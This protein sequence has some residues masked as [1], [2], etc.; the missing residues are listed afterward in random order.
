MHIAKCKKPVDIISSIGHSGKGK[1]HRKSK[2]NSDCQ[3]LGSKKENVW[4]DGAHDISRVLKSNYFVWYC[5]GE[6]MILHI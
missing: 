5:Y 3:G 2:K 6:Y 1:N 4:T